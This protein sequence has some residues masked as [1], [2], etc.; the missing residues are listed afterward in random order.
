MNKIKNNI[1]K[2]FVWEKYIEINDDVKDCYPT[3]EGAIRH[4][5][6]DGIKQNRLYKTEHLPDDFDW[7]IYLGLNPDVYSI[8]KNKTSSIMHYENHGFIEERF[9]K[10]EQVD[11]PEDFDWDY[12]CINNPS[13][14]ISSKINAVAHY[15]KIGKKKEL[16]YILDKNNIT[17]PT[18]FNWI[19][20]QKLN[21]LDKTCLD[22]K[23]AIT[24]YLI[25]G[26]E[27]KLSYK[28][29]DN[30]IPDDFDWITYSEINTD[31]KE[32]F[33]TKELA[34]YH[35]YIT[36][37][38]EGRVYK[39][40]HI[41]DDFDWE[42]Y[43]QLNE[44]IPEQ[45]KINEYTVKLHYDVF[46]FI[47]KLVYKGDFGHIPK[48]FD[49]ETY[50][51]LNDDIK[52]VC[53]TEILAK[54]HYDT[55]GIYQNRLYKKTT[56]PIITN[57]YYAY[58]FLFHKYILNIT[59]KSTSIPYETINHNKLKRNSLIVAHLHCYDITTFDEFY[60]EYINKIMAYCNNIIITYSIGEIENITEKR[61]IY[62][63][64]LNKGMDIGGKF[65]CVDYLKNNSVKYK[66]ILFLH[67]KT[68]P[69]MRKLYWEPILS[70][71]GRI[72]KQ[73]QKQTEYGIF[74]PPLIYM[75]DYATIIYKDQFVN[76]D[77]VTSKW[78]F[79]NSLYLNDIDRYF[80]YNT[81]N[82]FFP[83]GNCFVCNSEIANA[84]YGDTI[85]YNLLNNKLTMDIVWIKS[86]YGS[87][88]FP[89]GNNITEIYNFFKSVNNQKLF[90]NNIAWGA[91]HEGHP[92][93]MYEHSFERIVFKV[94]QKL[95]YKI[96]ILPYKQEKK[97]SR[98][99]QNMNDHI[100][101]IL[102]G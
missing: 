63:K 12:Y 69:Y 23:S 51:E 48:D 14:N 5:L 44:T 18:D 100:N 47:G 3:K 79:G 60:G 56:I 94:V 25:V 53:S 21:G 37:K 34:A 20:Y 70:N 16:S 90:P 43:I 26:K 67:S 62:I 99:L 88:G 52:C 6:N 33:G 59:K 77:N 91:G 81:T 28:I 54:K 87:R 75:G 72:S 95:Q 80:N 93:N 101:K 42:L 98:Q 24:H 22:E 84:L 57:S 102:L 50:V 61:F 41:P 83:E 86:L 82:Y 17:I 19:I 30:V 35:Y 10:L 13:L 4:Y 11:I 49:W 45:Y 64:C 89:V 9:Y 32:I 78:N 7:E 73:I 65:V 27:Q 39:F 71:I 31:V 74:V 92:D 66:S 46:G 29:P 85:I 36:G 8:C 38:N 68:D 97:Y 40:M 15:Y 2:D 55:Y 58:P 1:P 76:P 96:K